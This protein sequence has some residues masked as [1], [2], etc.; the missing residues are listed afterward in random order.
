MKV[1]VLGCGR[2]GT[3]LAWHA[4]T[5]EHEVILWGREDSANFKR[6]ESEGRNEYLALPEQVKL[7]SSLEQ[8]LES[9]YIIVSIS[10]QNLREFTREINYHAPVGKNFILCMKGIEAN[11][12]KRLS[13]VFNEEFAHPASVAIWVGPG[14]VQDFVA[15]IPNCMVI[16]SEDIE[17]T[18]GIVETLGS[19]LIRFYYGQDMIGNEIGAAAKNVMGIAAG[20]LDGLSCSSL[21]GALMARGAREI[22]R[23]VRAMGGNELTVYGLSHLGDYEATLFS[24]HSHNRR[25]GKLFV[26]GQRFEKLAEGVETVR[27]L[28]FLSQL[29]DVE[30][31]ICNA[32]HSI[33]FEGKNA[34]DVLLDLFLRPVKFEF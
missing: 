33:I 15:G 34:K 10:S 8:A 28:R 11:T 29:H 17:Y 13:Q 26:S 12:G 30:L 1:S 9:D 6:L 23:L 19:D 22:S 32:I 14:H 21:K 24:A 18:K 25:F 3:F 20:M 5:V 7:C 2:W 27:A 16:G 4:S 31:P